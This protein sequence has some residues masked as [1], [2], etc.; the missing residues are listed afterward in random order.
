MASG[1]FQE[2]NEKVFTFLKI[3]HLSS[4]FYFNVNNS[5]YLMVNGVPSHLENDGHRKKYGSYVICHFNSPNIFLY[6]LIVCLNINRCLNQSVHHISNTQI[7]QKWS[8]NCSG[9]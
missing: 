6:P 8:L 1:L 7:I 2:N 9:Q 4:P 5:L 3:G